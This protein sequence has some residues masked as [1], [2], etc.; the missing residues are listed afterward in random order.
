M[1]DSDRPT[2]DDAERARP[3]RPSAAQSA[4]SARRH[5]L[6]NAPLRYEADSATHARVD[7]GHPDSSS[8]QSGPISVTDA[9]SRTSALVATMRDTIEHYVVARREMGEPIWRIVGEVRALVGRADTHLLTP[10]AR[11]PLVDDVVRWTL[12]AYLAVSLCSVIP[13][14]R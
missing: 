1:H 4:R 10:D 8:S 14:H 12:Q 7:H 13:A 6:P 3:G 9:T 2:S 11:A 5:R